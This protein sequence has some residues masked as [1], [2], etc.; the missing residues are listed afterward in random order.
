MLL[1]AQTFEK[2]VAAQA[3]QFC[4]FPMPRRG[5]SRTVNDIDFPDFRLPTAVQD[6]SHEWSAT[7]YLQEEVEAPRVRR[8]ESQRERFSMS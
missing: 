6:E 4:R 2:R 1:M 5:L 3:S 7:I 8:L